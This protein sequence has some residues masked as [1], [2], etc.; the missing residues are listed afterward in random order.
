MIDDY[1]NPKGENIENVAHELQANETLIGFYGVID[2]K[3]YF[4]TF[5]FIV[6]VIN[7]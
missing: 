4:R 3:E 5:G 2:D 6:K 1:H 7:N